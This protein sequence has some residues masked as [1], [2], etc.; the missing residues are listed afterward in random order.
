MGAGAAYKCLIRYEEW[1]PPVWYLMQIVIMFGLMYFYM[2]DPTTRA[3]LIH[4]VVFCVL[5]AYLATWVICK[6]LDLLI[7]VRG[8]PRASY[9]WLTCHK[10]SGSRLG[11]HS[12]H[13]LPK[14]A[15]GRAVQKR[16]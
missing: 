11:T 9:R 4:I 2:T 7:R 1:E 13:S 6:V 14:S 10:S 8:V 5:V 3:P 12:Q 15:P 16:R